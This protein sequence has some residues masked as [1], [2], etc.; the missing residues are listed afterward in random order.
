MLQSAVLSVNASLTI[1]HDAVLDIGAA[2]ASI[3]SCRARR[4]AAYSVLAGTLALLGPGDGAGGGSVVLGANV[5][6]VGLFHNGNS[7]I[8]NDFAPAAGFSGTGQ[9]VLGDLRPAQCPDLR[10]RPIQRASAA[11]DLASLDFGTLHVGDAA[12]LHYGLINLSGNAGYVAQGAVQTLVNGG[13][14]T[15]LALSGSGVTPQNFG[16]APRGGT[17]TFEVTLD[18]AEALLLQDQ[19]V[20]IGFEFN[21]FQ[22][23]TGTTLPITGAVLNYAEPG[24]ELASGPGTLERGGRALDAR[25]RHAWPRAATPARRCSRSATSPRHRPTTW[26]AA[27]TSRATASRSTGAEPF[28]GLAAGDA[29]AALQPATRH[30]GARARMRRRSR[31]TR[32]AAMPPASSATCRR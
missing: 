4:S 30:R 7:G 5:L 19:A 12:V 10:P 26:A 17:A 6:E 25:P 21:R 31:C 13:N 23:D 11:Q 32:P 28:A 29:L 16:I 22:F 9:V 3:D 20:H 14:V 15:D 2:A 1:G 24:F 27:S 18:T 8:G